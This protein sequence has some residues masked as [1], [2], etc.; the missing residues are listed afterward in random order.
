MIELIDQCAQAETVTEKNKFVLEF[1]ALLASPREE[2]DGFLPFGMG[3]LGFPCKGMQVGNK[4]CDKFMC[5]RILGQSIVQMI[6][7]EG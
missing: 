5:A 6:Y 3:E 4:R 2:F 1:S 7:T